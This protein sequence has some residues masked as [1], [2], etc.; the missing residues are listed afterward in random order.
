MPIESAATH[1][2]PGSAWRAK[3]P[4]FHRRSI[5]CQTARPAPSGTS[6][7]KLLVRSAMPAKT[8]TTVG[9]ARRLSSDQGLHQS[10]DRNTMDTQNVSG[11][12]V[13]KGRPYR[14]VL[15]KPRKNRAAK[16]PRKALPPE[17]RHAESP[18]A[19]AVSMVQATLGQRSATGLHQAPQ[20]VLSSPCQNSSGGLV[21]RMSVISL[22][23]GSQCPAS[24][25][26]RVICM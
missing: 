9:N 25:V 17:S 16:V 21:F 12:F 20:F 24:A 22:C 6:W 18:V 4:R 14:Y 26:A 5:R 10:T 3:A 1:A 11:G 7:A 8:P 15:K 2:S 23:S 19:R 13:R